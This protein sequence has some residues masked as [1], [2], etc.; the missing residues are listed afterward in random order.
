MDK[1][2][3]KNIDINAD[4][5]KIISKIYYDPAG[6]GSMQTTY[7]DAKKIDKSIKYQD[8]KNWFENN[9]E[10]KTQLRGFNSYVASKPYQECQI[11]LMF[12]YDLKDP[13]YIGGLL[14]V[15][16]LTKFCQVIPIKAK[17]IQP[18][19][20]ALTLGIQKMSNTTHTI[21]PHS[22][23]SDDEG[24]LNSNEIQNYLSEHKIKHIV[25]RSH[26][27]V[28]ERTIGTIK[29]MIYKRIGKTKT[30]WIDVLY[31]VLLT[32]NFKLKHSTIGMTPA[33]ARKPENKFDVKMRLEMHRVHKRRY[34]DVHVG[35]KVKMYQ[36]K[37]TFHKQHISVW[38]DNAY[39]V[40]NISEF[41]GQQFYHVRGRNKALLRSEILL[42][43]SEE[44]DIKI[45]FVNKIML[46]S[47]EEIVK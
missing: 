33:E 39:E 32:Y 27:N 2:I 37:D 25:T 7:E 18:V 19:F 36:K 42:A 12:C 29:S 45:H 26:A 11:D 14:L 6:Y 22:L 3:D 31:P 13:E 21:Y 47:E 23:Y 35:D 20:D 24:A 40:T 17:T 30:R 5:N 44:L 8:V 34:P 46:D 10:R 1:N 43:R 16:I 28:A 4:K 38:T 41:D 9:I 15:D